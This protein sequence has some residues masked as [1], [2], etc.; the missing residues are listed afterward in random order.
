MKRTKKTGRSAPRP[1]PHGDK[2]AQALQALKDY[3]VPEVARQLDTPAATVARWAKEA[4]VKPPD[5]RMRRHHAPPLPAA[6]APSAPPPARNGNGRPEICGR[7]GA[8]R[9]LA[10]VGGQTVYQ[11]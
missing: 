7:D 3:S 10:R 8:Q 4:G 5:G 6:P 11:S 1:S 9:C 2:R